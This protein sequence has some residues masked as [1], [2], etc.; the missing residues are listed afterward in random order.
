LGTPAIE[1]KLYADLKKGPFSGPPFS[2]LA[3]GEQLCCHL[4]FTKTRLDYWCP[5]LFRHSATGTCSR[6]CILP[7]LTRHRSLQRR[8]HCSRCFCSAGRG[9]GICPAGT[10]AFSSFSCWLH[11]SPL[12]GAMPFSIFCV[13][14]QFGT[15]NS[16]R[17]FNLPQGIF[18]LVLGGRVHHCCLPSSAA[19][20]NQFSRDACCTAL[21]S[22]FSSDLRVRNGTANSRPPCVKHI[23]T[24]AARIMPALLA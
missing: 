12:I 13:R 16:S 1:Q 14:T 22:V 11:A 20:P 17:N 3:V 23:I 6:A 19:M 18:P 8:N 9:V 10:L 24:R 7:D 2:I 4:W 21:F 15:F 5:A